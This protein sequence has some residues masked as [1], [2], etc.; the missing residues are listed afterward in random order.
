[1]VTSSRFL[2]SSQDTLQTGVGGL[3]GWGR[4]TARWPGEPEL[5]CVPFIGHQG[6]C[7]SS[8]LDMSVGVK[9]KAGETQP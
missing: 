1:M 7:I 6:K 3:G 5:R 2:P 8:D 4:G 9:R